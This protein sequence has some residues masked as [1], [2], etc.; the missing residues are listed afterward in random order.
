[1]EDSGIPSCLA[2]PGCSATEKN[3]AVQVLEL[4][5]QDSQEIDM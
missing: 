4:S 5:I 2:C 3:T 1:M